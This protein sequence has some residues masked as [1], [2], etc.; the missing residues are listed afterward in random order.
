MAYTAGSGTYF[1][2]ANAANL[3]TGATLNAAG[4]TNGTAVQVDRPGEVQ[5]RLET[6][7]VTGTTPTLSIELQASD[8]ATFATG[9]LSLG[10][11]TLLSGNAASQ[12]N[13]DKEI[14]ARVY[15]TYVRAVVTAGGTSPVYTGSTLK[16]VQPHFKRDGTFTAAV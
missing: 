16:V 13:V 12:S 1:A 11:L 6:S 7:T 14:N 5:F 8:D 10:R 15:N 2:D 9:V 3:L 4:T